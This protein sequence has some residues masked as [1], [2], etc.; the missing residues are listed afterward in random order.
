M[1]GY[2]RVYPTLDRAQ[3]AVAPYANLGHQ[4]PA[5]IAEHFDLNITARPSDYAA[6]FYVARL[7]PD[8][9][10]I[11]DVGGSAGNLFYCYQSYLDFRPDLVWTVYDL[12]E[13]IALGRALAAERGENRLVFTDDWQMASGC[14]L[15]LIS[16]SLHYFEEPLASRLL[17]L[18]TKPRYIL[19][20][21]TPA[22]ISANNGNRAGR[23][24]LPSRL[25]VAQSRHAD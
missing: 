1:L 11:F 15:M 12:P 5:N 18:P 2:R 3:S 10:A 7:V 14:D 4:H 13:P 20:N 8:L 9:K 25:P 22:D 24:R 16:G 17:R 6:L 23:W 19:I 21:R